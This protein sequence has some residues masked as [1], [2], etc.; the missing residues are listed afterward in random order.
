MEVANGVAGGMLT[1]RKFQPKE[2]TGR[3][4]GGGEGN[5]AYRGML[6]RGSCF[7]GKVS[8]GG[9]GSLAEGG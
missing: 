2:N 1:S 8:L 7:K 3:W 4:G 9:G 6:G 5:P